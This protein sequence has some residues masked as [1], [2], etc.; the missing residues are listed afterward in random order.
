MNQP[1]SGPGAPAAMPFPA[2]AGR[3][4]VLR[5]IFEGGAVQVHEV[6]HRA[7]GRRLAAKTLRA[8]ASAQPA[9]RDRLRR[10]GRALAAAR[11]PNVVDVID[12][13][14][15]PSWGQFL[16]LELVEG[17]SLDGIL[18]ARG[19]LPAADAVGVAAQVASALGVG[20][21]RGVVHGDVRP[22]NIVVARREDG[23]E[24]VKLLGYGLAQLAAP[25][26]Q[27]APSDAPEILPAGD[28]RGLATT[29]FEALAGEPPAAATFAAQST[30]LAGRLGND[31]AAALSAGLETDPA[32]QLRDPRQFVER[33]ARAAAVVVGATSLLGLPNAR[34]SDTPP[35]R[36]YPRAAYRAPV[37]VTIG[38][39][40]I[41]G[42]VSDI[43]EG[44][45][46][47]I[48]PQSAPTGVAA[49]LKMALPLLGDMVTVDAKVRWGRAAK[50][51]A[52]I[53]LEFEN[54]PDHARAAIVEYVRLMGG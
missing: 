20:H 49:R 50:G 27:A 51:L 6:V 14:V 21:A 23:V 16:V 54:L 8:D 1:A 47:V 9:L 46:Q 44:G 10:E 4:D 7:T 13:G 53:G 29:I 39:L 5:L 42:H 24:V 11:H 33:L 31:V 15:C 52:A 2:L 37:R 12:A 19:T 36:V 43:S 22:R 34:A 45:V 25:A 38:N 28:V 3:Y 48:S 26:G 30:T 41:D 40:S 35:R 18:A 32:K 17:R